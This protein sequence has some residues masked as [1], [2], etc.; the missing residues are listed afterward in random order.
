MTRALERDLSRL[1]LDR[2]GSVL[3]IVTFGIV[4]LTAVAALVIDLGIMLTAR[5]EAQ[6]AAEA[7]AHAGAGYLL[8]APNDEDG[9]RD[10]ARLFA[11]RNTVRNVGVTV[12]DEDI[13]VD[14]TLQLVRVR[15]QASRDRGN[16]IPTVFARVIGIDDVQVDAVAAA[17]AWPGAG[18]NCVLPLIIPDRWSKSTTPPYVWPTMSE[19]FIPATDLYL[20]YGSADPRPPTGYGTPDRGWQI[21]ITS[22]TSNNAPSPGW[23]Y[24]IRLPGASGTNDF[25]DAVT[26]CWESETLYQIGMEVIK[27]PGNFGVPTG[28]AFQDL[29]SLDPNAVWNSSA[30]DGNG[31]VT[32]SG[33]Q[34]CRGSARIRPIL[35]FSPEEWPVIPNGAHEVTVSNFAGVFVESATGQGDVWVRFIEYTA[36]QPAETWSLTSNLPKILRIV[37]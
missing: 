4:G 24:K 20:P 14:L 32:S 29:I 28:G 8:F 2:R 6:R 3:A 36:V 33:S 27:E 1:R 26:G 15:V 9:A 11:E 5:S 35:M 17:Q 19:T 37:E 30:N 21:Q 23:Y 7:G 31:C 34:V 18:V 22:G 13:E 16:A 25:R 10:A 12:L